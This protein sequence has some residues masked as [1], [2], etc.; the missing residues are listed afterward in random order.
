MLRKPQGHVKQVFQILRDNKMYTKL[1]KCVFAVQEIQFLGYL[2][3]CSG[4]RMDSEKVRA[5]LDWDR[6]ENLKALQHFLG[7][8]NFYQKFIRNYSAIV[9]PLTDM[10]RKGSDFS[11][12][13][14]AALNAFSSLKDCFAK[15]PILSQSDASQPFIVEVDALEFLVHWRGYGPEERTWVAAS[16]VNAPRSPVV[17]YVKF[18]GLR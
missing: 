5:V 4:F 1:E 18:G 9:K 11:N 17:A 6:P 8:T 10:T 13:S 15:A 3:S 14:E 12:W 16:E 2:L 7:F